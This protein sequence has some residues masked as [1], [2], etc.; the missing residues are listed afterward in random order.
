M[1]PWGRKS[2]LMTAEGCA[3]GSARSA[4]P[5]RLSLQLNHPPFACLHPGKCGWKQ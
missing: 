1:P 5:H 3:G 2:F 4:D